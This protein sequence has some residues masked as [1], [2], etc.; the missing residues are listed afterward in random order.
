MSLKQKTK[1]LAEFSVFPLGEQGTSIGKF[2][3]EAIVK[4][5]KI[6]GLKCE[7]TAMGSI[8]EADNLDKIFEAVKIAH[9]SLIAMGIK[10]VESTLRIDD[11]RDK[12]R[13]MKDKVEAVNKYLSQIK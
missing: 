4:I 13:T 2:V 8:L 11:R 3:A 12:S 5:N 6:D 1:V 7:V 9:E 10:R